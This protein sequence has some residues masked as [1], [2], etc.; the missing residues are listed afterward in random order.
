MSIRRWFCFVLLLILSACHPGVE[1]HNQQFT[2][3]TTVYP[4]QFIADEIVGSHGLVTSI[5]PPGVDAHTY[6]PT[7]E[8]IKK[9]ANSDIFIYM[10]PQMEGFAE[11]TANALHTEETIFIDVSNHR[12]L[13]IKEDHDHHGEDMNLDPHLW[14]DPLRLLDLAALIKNELIHLT[15]HLEETF[16]ENFS[17]LKTS[18]QK[19][20]QNYMETFQEKSNKYMLVTHAAYGYWEDRYGLQQIP[21]SGLAL[22]NEPSQKELIQIVEQAKEQEL[23]FVVYEQNSSDRIAKI[24]QDHLQA[25]AVTLHNLEVLTDE[26]LANDEDY[27]SLMKKNLRTLDKI[28]D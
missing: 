15:P 3:Y 24:I 17:T 1:E 22:G 2:I 23:T 4:L 12:E 9:I 28:T 5:L 18:L 13:F 27:L 19:L 14:L 7:S 8:D 20:D 6:E 25:E 10:G 21:I 16:E 26:D 11:T